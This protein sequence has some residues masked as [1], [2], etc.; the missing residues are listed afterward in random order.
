MDMNSSHDSQD[1]LSANIDAAA[2]KVTIGARYAH[3]KDKDR[4]YTVLALAL[5]EEDGEP[6][7]V[8]QAQYE[9][10]ITWVRPVSSWLQ[11]VDMG[12]GRHVP[13]FVRVD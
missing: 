13:R 5:R 1:K 6:C 7:V 12:G 4:T 8:Y 10:R 11:I 3:Y 2:A 9:Q